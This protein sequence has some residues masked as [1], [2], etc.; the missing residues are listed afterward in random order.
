MNFQRL[1]PRPKPLI[2]V[3][4]L[5]PLPGAP[6]Y[7]GKMEEIL[8]AA[9]AEALQY[10]KHGVDGLI[11]ENFRDRP[12][13][14]GAVPPETIAALA[15]AAREVRQAVT[16]IPLGVNVLRNDAHAAL[17]IAI[18]SEAQFI[19]VNVHL[20]AVVADQGII[21]GLGHETTRLRRALES[22][23]L[24]FADVGVKHAVALAERN[25][26][27]E[28]QDVAERGLADALI[29]SGQLTGKAASVDDL[30]KVK[31]KTSIP[32]LIGSGIT[33][34][35]LP[36][37]HAEADG[38]IVGSTFKKAGRADNEIEESRLQ[39]FMAKLASCRA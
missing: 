9:R 26:A 5:L 2:G 16:R 8:A 3:I 14:P 29:V 21:Q 35:N 17:A 22:E 10:E 24:I 18:A 34:D 4:H 32:V 38:F 28:A 31:A 15:V 11:L 33:A 13:F 20:G 7:G 12:F 36:Q 39:A 27:L 23:V 30:R 37:F 25:L 19:R 6:L 1:F